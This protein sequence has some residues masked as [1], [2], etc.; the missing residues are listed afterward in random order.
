MASNTD[1]ASNVTLHFL[2][3][4]FSQQLYGKYCLADMVMSALSGRSDGEY[5]DGSYSLVDIGPDVDEDELI[6]GKILFE[7]SCWTDWVARARI[8]T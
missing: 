3:G 7:K 4:H 6:E 2:G 8:Q 1:I 5:V